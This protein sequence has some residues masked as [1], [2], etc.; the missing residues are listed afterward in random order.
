MYRNKSRALFDHGQVKRGKQRKREAERGFLS[1]QPLSFLGWIMRWDSG[2]PW[3]QGVQ[4]SHG[5]NYAGA[6]IFFF[7]SH[8]SL[9]KVGDKDD[10]RR[11]LL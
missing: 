4:G 2:E 1:V 10:R 3:G 11:R 5:L 7:S 6:S 8:P 9:R